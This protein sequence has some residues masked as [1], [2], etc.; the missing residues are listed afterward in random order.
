[1]IKAL[2]AQKIFGLE[3][4]DVI[5]GGGDNDQINGRSGL[6]QCNGGGVTAAACEITLNVL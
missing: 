4:D 5:R 3:G 6:V 1:V 2:G